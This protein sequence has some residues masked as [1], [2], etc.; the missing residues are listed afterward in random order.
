MKGFGADPGLWPYGSYELAGSHS[1]TVGIAYQKR[2]VGK[3]ENFASVRGSDSEPDI[4]ERFIIFFYMLM[5]E[6]KL[7][8]INLRKPEISKL[9]KDL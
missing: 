6:I 4:E 8:N 5:T 9:Y 1:S 3:I 7:S 2:E